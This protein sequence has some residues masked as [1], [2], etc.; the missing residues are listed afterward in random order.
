MSH[1]ESFWEIVEQS[2]PLD[3]DDSSDTTCF[4]ELTPQQAIDEANLLD[5]LVE[6]GHFSACEAADFWLDVDYM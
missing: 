2:E 5:W 6:R 3:T 4:G 1:T